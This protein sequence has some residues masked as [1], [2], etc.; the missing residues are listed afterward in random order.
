MSKSNQKL[1]QNTKGDSK[2]IKV[3]HDESAALTEFE[4]FALRENGEE[5][6]IGGGSF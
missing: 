4:M 5:A 3:R 6:V 1:D 2:L